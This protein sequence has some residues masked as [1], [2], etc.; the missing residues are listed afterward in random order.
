MLPFVCVCVCVCLG[1]QMGHF[2]TMGPAMVRS[3]F[4]LVKATSL[5]SIP[6]SR[7]PIPSLI[8]LACRRQPFPRLATL[9]E[10]LC[11]QG[12]LSGVWGTQVELNVTGVS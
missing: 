11:C 10:P 9:T 12:L 8:Y 5:L 2:G 7:V 1:L 6:L 3:N 4:P